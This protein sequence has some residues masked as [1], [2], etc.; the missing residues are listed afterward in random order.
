MATTT[1]AKIVHYVV[2]LSHL[3]IRAVAPHCQAEQGSQ[4]VEQLQPLLQAP[5]GA[6]ICPARR[7]PPTQS[8]HHPV[9]Q[10]HSRQYCQDRGLSFGSVKQKQASP[11]E[12]EFCH[13]FVSYA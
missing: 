7:L 1:L 2:L 11:W 9:T 3:F 6:V 4:G 12:S 5:G 10:L 8:I 13:F